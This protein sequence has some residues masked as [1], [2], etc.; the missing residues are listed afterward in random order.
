MLALIPLLA[1][2]ATGDSLPRGVPPS[3]ALEA[4]GASFAVHRQP[5]IP[6]VSVRMSLLADDPPGYAGAGHL[7]QHLLLPTLRTQ[8]ARVGGEV[9][10]ERSADALVYT[11]TGPTKELA[12][13]VGV[14]RST[15]RPPAPTSAALLRASRELAEERLSE[16]ESAD[17][18]VRSALRARLFPRDLS[19]AGTERSATRFQARDIPAIW[20]RMYQPEQL[21]VLAVG[22]VTLTEL[23]EAFGTL[24][25]GADVAANE[26]A[27]DTVSLAPLVPAE[28]TRGWLGAG[29]PATG[30]EPAAVSVTA[31]ILHDQLHD[32]IPGASVTA[33]HWW[34]HEGQALV[35]VIGEPAPLVGAARHALN[36]L[37]SGLDVRLTE[38]SVRAAAR[39]L[40]R[41]MLFYSRTP[42]RMAEILGRF[43][44]RSGDP[45]AAEVFYGQLAEVDL[46]A[47]RAVLQHMMDHTPA[48]VE[49]AASL[50]PPAR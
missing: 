16:W 13:L 40:R 5:A 15:L 38:R 36:T 48:R 46:D 23:R 26:E 12:F 41:E 18:H 14:L 10:M 49:I 19:A 44:D 29:Y 24:P 50:P 27:E 7:I 45:N 22:D 21:S 39:S 3:A 2:L 4:P 9:E 33:E 30:L 17:Q 1:V 35:I 43:A 47:V 6:L 11:L 37:A 31:R 8:V 20:R 32:Q 28:A 34:T 42:D 25:S